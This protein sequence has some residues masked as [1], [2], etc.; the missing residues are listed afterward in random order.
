[1]FGTIMSTIVPDCGIA[2]NGTPPASI[3]VVTLRNLICSSRSCIQPV[4]NPGRLPGFEPVQASFTD[5]SGPVMNAANAM[6]ASRSS[7]PPTM[8]GLKMWKFHAAEHHGT[9]H[10]PFGISPS[11]ITQPPHQRC[12]RSS[13]VARFALSSMTAYSLGWLAR[14]AQLPSDEQRILVLRLR[15]GQRRTRRD[16]IR[17][18]RTM[19]LGAACLQRCLRPRIVDDDHL[20]MWML[21][22][23]IQS[24]AAASPGMRHEAIGRIARVRPRD[25]PVPGLAC[26][27]LDLARV[28]HQVIP[29]R[30][31]LFRIEA[32]ITEDL[33]IPDQRHGLVVRRHAIDLAVPGYRLHRA[34]PK[35]PPSCD[36]HP[37]AAVREASPSPRVPG[38]H[39]S[40]SRA[41]DGAALPSAACTRFGGN[42]SVDAEARSFSSTV[43][44]LG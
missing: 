7:P 31:R 18:A 33:R 24:S 5:H 30:R 15:V 17:R 6:A 8:L 21:L 10:V 22:G 1:M 12:L 16:R 26:L 20:V 44:M 27:L 23:L 28:R 42:S 37:L 29:G 4:R 40:I 32:R 39:N 38:L 3:D 19:C 25:E 36:R 13:P 9:P 43:V 14:R 34:R 11:R 2:G 35:N 41:T